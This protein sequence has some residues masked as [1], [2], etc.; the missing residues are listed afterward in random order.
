MMDIKD[1][2]KLVK[3]SPRDVVIL[4]HRNP[5]GDAIGSSISLKLYLEKYRH[6]VKIV[7][8]SELPPNFDFINNI[9]DIIVFDNDRD[10]A[11]EA[12]RNAGLLF[13]V[14]FNSLDRIDKIGETFQNNQSPKVVI[15]HHL[16]PEPFANFYISDTTASSTAELIYHLIECLNDEN[17][18]TK[19]MGTAIFLGII[20]DTGSFKYNTRPQTYEI[21]AK[22]KRIGVDDNKLQNNIYNNL[23]EKNLRLLGHCLAN[24]MELLAGGRAA[25]IYLNKDDYQ[26]FQIGRGDTE[27]II[28]YLLMIKTV[29]L[30]VFVMEQPT[31]IKLSLRSKG[32]VSVQALASSH[33]NGGGHKNASG[34]YAYA[35]LDDILEKVRR[36]VPHYLVFD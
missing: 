26:L 10:V 13:C 36:V 5:D 23:N 19:E 1:I 7:F 22:L 17:L 2:E 16:D 4:S 6:A 24:R 34:G 8:P 11:L 25:M 12:I 33:F 35:K 28:N 27:G 31:V 18:I 9:Q 3:G 32:D 15:D 29:Q 21:G 14:D 20:T 30:A